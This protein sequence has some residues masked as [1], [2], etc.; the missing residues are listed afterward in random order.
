MEFA[1]CPDCKK[2][3]SSLVCNRVPIEQAKNTFIDLILCPH[4]GRVMITIP[5]LVVES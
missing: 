1:H 3:L 4:C 5:H 2:P